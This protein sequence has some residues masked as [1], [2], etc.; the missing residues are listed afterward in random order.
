[1]A[2]AKQDYPIADNMAFQRRSWAVERA[3]WWIMG[4]AVVVAALGLLSHGS[5]SR[6][7]A[8]TNDSR[9]AISYERLERREASSRF[10]IRAQP[11]ETG[12]EI[13]LR[14]G[15]GF[16]ENYEIRTITPSP[17]RAAASAAGYQGAFASAAGGSEIHITARA[18]RFGFAR[19]TGEVPGL[20]TID[21]RQFIFP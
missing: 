11:A 8:T 16:L 14:L 17:V 15:P 9:L 6:T 10:T 2:R 18:K 19:F 12:G 5:L 7:T 4:S 21:V 20:G 1:M 13:V 3:A